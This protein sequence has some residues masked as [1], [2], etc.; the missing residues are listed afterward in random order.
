MKIDALSAIHLYGHLAWADE[1]RRQQAQAHVRGQIVRASSQDGAMQ[2]KQALEGLAETACDLLGIKRGSVDH[3]RAI[4]IARVAAFGAE[5][6]P[7]YHNWMHTFE[8]AAHAAVLGS[9]EP[10]VTKRERYL[11]FIAALGHDAG[12]PGQVNPQPYY[13]ETHSWRLIKPHLTSLSQAEQDI[14]GYAILASDFKSGV[15]LIRAAYAEGDAAGHVPAN[16]K[17][18]AL[19][20]DA[21]L[22]GGTA[23]AGKNLLPKL[24]A[25]E[26]R[27]PDLARPANQLQFML[28]VP[29]ITSAAR[30]AGY[31]RAH[32]RVV[33][34]LAWRCIGA[35]EL[36]PELAA[37]VQAF[38]PPLELAAALQKAT[39]AAPDLA[40]SIER[41]QAI[42][43]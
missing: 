29:P 43:V 33:H 4:S 38:A 2:A 8:V 19:L 26:Q 36:T 14:I 7:A 28:S 9:N 40:L 32:A 6:Q 41:G 30:E 5:R 18:A 3:Q 27:T 35:R 16:V 37:S 20:A 10:G 15:P 12:H 17:L 42:A 31:A 1:E 22:A 39:A 13:N 21:D 23:A 24:L 34:D 11:L 25:E